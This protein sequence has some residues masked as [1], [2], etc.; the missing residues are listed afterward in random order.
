MMNTTTT[1]PVT[2]AATTTISTTNTTTTTTN[3]PGIMQSIA[4]FDFDFSFELFY[5]FLIFFFSKTIFF[6]WFVFL[7]I[8]IIKNRCPIQNKNIAQFQYFDCSVGIYDVRV[9]RDNLN[10]KV[11]ITMTGAHG[12]MGI[13]L[14]SQVMNGTYAIIVMLCS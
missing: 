12:W 8:L 1:M 9:M 14:G 5:F 3:S 11:T 2:T 10:E 13:G 7:C 4:Y 6:Y